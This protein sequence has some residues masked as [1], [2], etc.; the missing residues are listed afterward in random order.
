MAIL[1]Y[2]LFPN[3][4]LNSIQVYNG[5]IGKYVYEL[6]HRMSTWLESGLGSITITLPENVIDY[7]EITSE[8]EC[9]ID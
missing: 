7:I 1:T 6:L 5:G 9:N 8:F 2:A 3:N 4:M